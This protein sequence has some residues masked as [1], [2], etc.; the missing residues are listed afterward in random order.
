MGQT[1][2]EVSSRGPSVWSQAHRITSLVFSL[3]ICSMGAMRV[4]E[5]RGEKQGALTALIHVI[6]NP[7]CSESGLAVFPT[8]ILTYSLLPA[9]L[10][11]GFYQESTCPFLSLDMPLPGQSPA[12]LFK[13]S[14]PS[15]P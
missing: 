2:A 13:H 1:Q 12:V 15:E 9:L 4:E 6:M 10:G 11:S 8:G 14:L 3:V 7:S 5:I